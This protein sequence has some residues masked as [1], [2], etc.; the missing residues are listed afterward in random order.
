MK[1]RKLLDKLTFSL[2]INEDSTLKGLMRK[3]KHV[4]PC[5]NIP[6]TFGTSVHNQLLSVSF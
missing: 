5:K 2:T 3:G 6:I 4:A 1:Y